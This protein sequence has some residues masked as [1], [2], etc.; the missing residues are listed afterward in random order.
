MVFLFICATFK[1]RGGPDF[2]K[3]YSCDISSL[4]KAIGPDGLEFG[5]TSIL[6]TADSGE[7][8]YVDLIFDK[9]TNIDRKDILKLE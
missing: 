1:Y 6:V 4:A 8:K 2:A 3:N 7:A 5:R 9:R